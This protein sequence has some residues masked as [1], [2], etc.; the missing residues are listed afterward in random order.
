MSNGRLH[1]ATRNEKN[2]HPRKNEKGLI[3]IPFRLLDFSV[4]HFFEKSICEKQQAN[5]Q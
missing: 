4:V 1:I 3:E 2:L 5:D